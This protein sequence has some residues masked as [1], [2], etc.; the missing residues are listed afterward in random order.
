MPLHIDNTVIEGV[1]AATL[2]LVI[3]T[4]DPVPVTR[5][6]NG[7]QTSAKQYGPDYSRAYWSLEI[8]V[9][10]DQMEL[11]YEI[12]DECNPRFEAPMDGGSF[13]AR[14][15][16][17]SGTR[18]IAAD[19]NEPSYGVH[20][21]ALEGTIVEIVHWP[22]K[23]AAYVRWT[24]DYEDWRSGST[25]RIPFCFEGEV[26]FTGIEMHVKQETDATTILCHVLP[27]LDQS[28]FVMILGREMKLGP[29]VQDDRRCWRE[30]FWRPTS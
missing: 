28:A 22:R 21:P 11:P 23:D 19:D 2:K 17:L 4:E 3:S 12:L 27:N 15:D 8:I 5:I 26:A 24:A 9:A 13:P 29:L 25:L 7:R 14:M 30:V 6:L 10:L 20:G 1:Y 18:L 16:Q